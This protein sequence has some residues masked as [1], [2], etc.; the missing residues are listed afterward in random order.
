M[1][2]LVFHPDAPDEASFVF[3]VYRIDVEHQAA[4]FAQKLASYILDPIVLPV[5]A[6]HVQENHLQEAARQKFRAE[7]LGPASDDPV[8][9]PGV[10]VQRD[11]V[12][13]PR[14]IGASQEVLV[15]ARSRSRLLVGPELLD[16]RLDQR[17][18]LAHQADFGPLLRHD[19][20]DHV[21]GG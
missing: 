20:F 8:L 5:E 17:R 1:K 13:T 19:L 16:V 12:Y 6:G 9:Q 18:V 21:F 10:F 2:I 4:H 15:A 3:P 7:K 11:Q 14:Q